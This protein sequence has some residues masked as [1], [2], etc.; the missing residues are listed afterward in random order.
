MFSIVRKTAG[1][2]Q[3]G[4]IS[5]QQAQQIIAFEK[6]KKS[7]FSLFSI[8]L[9]LGFFSVVAG[10]IAVISSNWWLIPNELKITGLFLFLITTA[11]LLARIK[12]QHPALFEGGLFFY[13][14]LLFA[15]IG[16]VGQVYHLKSDTYA[17]FLFWS[18]LAFPLLLLACNVLFGYIWE[19]IFIAA[20]SASP[21]G[22]EFWIF[23]FETF[24]SPLIMSFLAMALF[25][26][27]LRVEKAPIF[28]VPLRAISAFFTL[29]CLMNDYYNTS[30]FEAA[31]LKTP[32]LFSLL[33]I[34]FCFFITQ[35]EIYNRSEKKAVLI[36]TG[37]YFLLFLLPAFQRS[38][39]FV[40]LIIL[41][42]FVFAAY[43]FGSQKAVRLLVVVTAIRILLAFFN[44][45]GSLMY[46]GIGLI[47]SGM[48][49]L[50]IAYAC[51]KFDAY[52]KLKV[53]KGIQH[54]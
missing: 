50:G 17:A 12:K 45:F 25:F 26:T 18:V 24:S 15:A 52:V 6:N 20:L 32:I 54:D 47:L 21:W 28:V 4:L 37:L 43:V 11:V 23:V 14:L 49:I 31:Y 39:Y 19:F 10:V 2:V 8:I 41:I 13:M 53:G 35:S 40:Q 36:M 27:V 42:G 5:E 46:T 3:N 7:I 22:Q 16:L 1:W 34:G 48:V 9:F 30:F 51:F 33:V 38:N 29:F 44:L